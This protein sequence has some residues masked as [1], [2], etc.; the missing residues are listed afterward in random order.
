MI[1]KR[2]VFWRKD[3]ETGNLT[4]YT[5]HKDHPGSS[6]WHI[7]NCE[8]NYSSATLA[9]IL[10]HLQGLRDIARDSGNAEKEYKWSFGSYDEYR[11]RVI[12]YTV[13][14]RMSN[15]NIWTNRVEPG[16]NLIMIW[17]KFLGNQK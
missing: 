17:N 11:A 12:D 1:E 16:Q 5:N 6:D 8:S 14:T 3:D 9:D 2:T 13:H 15:S 7:H 4:L 10:F